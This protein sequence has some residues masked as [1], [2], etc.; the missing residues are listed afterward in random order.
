MFAGSAQPAGPLPPYLTAAAAMQSR[1][2]PAFSYD[3][4]AGSNWADPLLA[5]EQPAARRRL[6]G[7]DARNTSTPRCSAPSERCAFTFA[8]FVLCDTRHAAHFALVPRERWSAAMLPAADWLALDERE[9][10]Q[11]VPYLLAVD[12]RTRCSA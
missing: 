3:A 6:V 8:D 1:A 11:R 10:A 2:F 4:A 12:G 5:R 9:A 7:R